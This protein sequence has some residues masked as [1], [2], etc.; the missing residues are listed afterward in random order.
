MA[1]TK[2]KPGIKTSEFW[3]LFGIY[4]LETLRVALT[5]GITTVEIVALIGAAITYIAQRGYLKK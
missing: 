5:G 3:L 4:I 2:V 1:N